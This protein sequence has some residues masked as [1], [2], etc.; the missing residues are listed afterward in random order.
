MDLGRLSISDVTVSHSELIPHLFPD[1]RDL[2]S[3]PALY[4]ATDSGSPERYLGAA[5]LAAP[6]EFE[7]PDFIT[8]IAVAEHCGYPAVGGIL[9]RHVIQIARQLQAPG[10]RTL[11]PARTDSANNLCQQF[12]FAAARK[13]R[14]YLVDLTAALG[15]AEQV[16]RALRQKVKLPGENEI[17]ALPVGKD[18]ALESLCVDVFGLVTH[19]LL[20]A[21]GEYSSEG[22]DYSCSTKLV[23][24]GQLVGCLVAGLE[25]EK[26][27]FDPLLISPGF[28]GAWAFPM[29]I[30]LTVKKILQ[31]GIETGLAT[32]HEDN[33]RMMAFMERLEA[34][35]LAC[36]TLYRLDFTETGSDCGDRR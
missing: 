17:S 23:H 5:L 8:D 3:A 29:L 6:G 9:L 19:G 36:E 15:A 11:T 24:R 31:R 10:L 34:R 7:A 2:K 21:S 33:R 22:L 1:A 18:E 28:R 12:G 30:S 35:P 14:H 20:R 27:I 4:L 32:V 26:A 25:K 13:T 16:L